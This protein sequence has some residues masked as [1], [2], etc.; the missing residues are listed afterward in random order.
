MT[1]RGP[2]ARKTVSES[3]FYQGMILTSPE[4]FSYLG[5]SSRE[6]PRQG[7]VSEGRR[8]IPSKS[9]TLPVSPEYTGPDVLRRHP[10]PGDLQRASGDNPLVRVEGR[11]ESVP[12]TET[13]KRKGRKSQRTV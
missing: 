11:L 5:S 12:P 7:G 6:G 4:S 3:N 13:R 9:L 2:V 10:T 8:G 1:T